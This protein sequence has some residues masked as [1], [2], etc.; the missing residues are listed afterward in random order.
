ME[1]AIEIEEKYFDPDHPTLATSYS[2][3]ATILRALG[4]LPEARRLMELAIEIDEKH[5][6][7]EHPSL[8]TRYTNLV[9][10]HR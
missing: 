3:L 7:P 8:A 5:F 4:D 1:R 10:R 9:P 6:D 2:N